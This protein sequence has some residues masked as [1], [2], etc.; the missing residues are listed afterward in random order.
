[1]FAVHSVTNGADSSTPTLVLPDGEVLNDSNK[2]LPRLV[3]LFPTAEGAS[4]N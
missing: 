3:E 4:R 2:I 1:M